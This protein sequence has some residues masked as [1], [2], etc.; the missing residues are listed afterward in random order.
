MSRSTRA[1]P[2]RKIVGRLFSTKTETVE[3]VWV[4]HRHGDRT[5]SRPLISENF[6][7]EEAKFWRS[8][9]PPIDRRYY[10]LLSNKFPAIIHESYNA[11]FLDADHGR[12]PYGFLSWK[13]MEQMYLRGQEISKRYNDN[14][15]ELMLDRFD[16]K[17]FS[18]NYLRTVKSCQCFLDGLL[19][20]PTLH[21]PKNIDNSD[22]SS[23][24]ESIDPSD[25]QTYSGVTIKVRDRKNDTLNAFDKSPDL[26]K[27]LVK[28]VVTQKEFI[29][30]DT[31]AA[32]L[33]ARLCNF[34][35]GLMN[36]KSYGGPSGINW[37]HAS[38]HFIC[39]SSH[40]VP[41]SKYSH[42]ESDLAEQTLQAISHS[43]TSH[44]AWRFRT[45]YQN[46][47]LLAAISGPPL[48][49]INDQIESII[50][51]GSLKKK[52]FMIYS[53]HDVTILSLL[54]GLGSDMLASEKELRSLGLSGSDDEER[55]R[56]WPE[57]AS[58]LVLE[59]L[60]VESSVNGEEGGYSIK[61]SLNGEPIRPVMAL[62]K[63]KEMMNAYDFAQ[64]TSNLNES[65][66]SELK[67][68]KTVDSGDRDMSGWTG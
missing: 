60:R 3:G 50:N 1:L 56:F 57:Y 17:A 35:P 59:L 65:V 32:T 24:Y 5:P 46:P 7:D 44:L 45:W 63:G 38:D 4:F 34:L 25:Y 13:G 33:A 21:K 48:A 6:M 64:L 26:M 52:P 10:D 54:Y 42:L 47:S 11:K 29:E 28:N 36:C 19:S 37:I 12:E 40:A 39:R 31:K 62:R 51:D 16:I 9:I 67:C 68:S 55:W 2:K 53:C 27:K 30:R 18:T 23:H 22:E 8:K 15:K 61:I 49:D 58:T 43:V 41:F 66:P 14:S 20:N